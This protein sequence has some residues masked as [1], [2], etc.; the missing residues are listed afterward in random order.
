MAA[1]V[2]GVLDYA[3]VGGELAE[4]DVD[5]DAL[6]RSVVEDLHLEPGA[7]PVRVGRTSDVHA[8]P[9]QLGIVVQNLLANALKHAPGSVVEISA[10]VVGDTWRLVVADHGPGIPQAERARVFE[11]LVQLDTAVD[12]SGLGLATCAR[13]ARAHAGAHRGERDPGRRNLRHRGAA[14]RPP[15]SRPGRQPR[16]GRTSPRDHHDGPRVRPGDLTLSGRAPR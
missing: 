13:I 6:V 15:P 12:G 1:L 7:G 3:R 8:D 9:V 16:C 10:E 5:V 14:P 4:V 11:S 2:H